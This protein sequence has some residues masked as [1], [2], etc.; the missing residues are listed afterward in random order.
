MK[1]MVWNIEKF[2]DAKFQDYE[3][4]PTAKL[5][6]K[7]KRQYNSATDRLFYMQMVVGAGGT[8]ADVPDVIAVLETMTARNTPLGQPMNALDSGGVL[9]FLQ[10]I[11]DETGNANW[12]VVPPIK[13]NP[14]KP[15]LH[16]GKWAAEEAV[17]VFYN[18]ATVTFEGPDYWN[19]AAIQRAAG[20]AAAYALPWNGATI[21]GGTTRAGR[22][23]HTDNAGTAVLFPNNMN[24]RPFMVDFREVGGATR[25]F[26][27]LFMHT[28]PQHGA[29]GTHVTGTQAIAQI[30]DM[31]PAQNTT[32]N[33]NYYI[34]CGDFN[35]ND[36]NAL[37]S[38]AAY[39]PLLAL[40]Y[41]YLI[42][43]T[44]TD[45]THYRRNH[46][47]DP[48]TPPFSYQHREILDNFF[49]RRN[50]GP[51]PWITVYRRISVDCVDGAPAPWG[52]AMY[53]D[54]GTIQGLPT[55]HGLAGPTATFHQWE[56]FWSIIA[57][58]DHL[59][60]YLRIP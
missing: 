4:Y 27:C 40:S 32:A 38:V 9:Q 39:A 11:K 51:Q 35:V 60:I 42:R 19:G 22:V 31:N 45:S 54:L 41:K 10:M 15:A 53:Q 1:L 33:P 29:T 12:R 52:T 3:Y 36:Y 37:E 14:P 18:S 48:L 26:R 23:D 25:L 56:N 5:S 28:S 7:R 55:G 47:A 49:V 8:A 30:A 21:A 17:A 57:T 46:D 43:T 16:V 2:T 13:C 34:A 20:G 24:R 59:P 58:S 6:T 50:P 44:N